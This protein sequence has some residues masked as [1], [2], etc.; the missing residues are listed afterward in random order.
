MITFDPESLIASDLLCFLAS[1]RNKSTKDDIVMSAVA[2]YNSEKIKN[3]KDRLFS[4]CNERPIQRK[5]CSSHPNPLVADVEDMVNLFAKMDEKD[6]VLPKFVAD[7]FDSFPPSSGFG[8]IAPLICALKD[9]LSALRHELIEVRQNNIRDMKAVDDV[10]CIKQDILDMKTLLFNKNSN[11]DDSPPQTNEVP[12][13][14][15]SENFRR[16][17]EAVKSNNRVQSR[18]NPPTV[19]P[20][21]NRRPSQNTIQPRNPN[22]QPRNPTIQPRNPTNSAMDDPR[23]SGA[24]RQKNISGTRATSTSGRLTG[25]PRIFDAFVGGCKNETSVQDIEEHCQSLGV[26]VKKCENLPN[27]SQWYSSFKI[28]AEWNDRETIL[29][30]E[31]WPQGV[32]VRKFYTPRRQLQI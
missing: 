30:A 6:S 29:N 25:A 9:E 16:Y 15:D 21:G 26:T 14:E 17:S 2:F 12:Q 8:C 22:S 32:F 4:I 18:R 1:S 7:S 19:A 13:S 5:A 3:A 27:K 10:F 28:S 24:R 11:R 23:T 31:F 20:T